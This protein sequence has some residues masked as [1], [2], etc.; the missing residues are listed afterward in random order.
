MGTIEIT[1]NVNDGWVETYATFW[2]S[3]HLGFWGTAFSSSETENPGCLKA[4]YE[5]SLCT[6][7][8]A[9]L[10]F[11][12]TS[13]NLPK[14]AKITGA[15]LKIYGYGYSSAV[16]ISVQEGTQ[17]DTLSLA[18]YSEFT[19]P[20]FGVNVFDFD[21]SG[22]NAIAFNEDGLSYLNQQ[23]GSTAKLCLREYDHDYLDVQPNDI[24]KSGMYFSDVSGSDRK[25]VLE[26]TYVNIESPVTVVGSPS[27]GEVYRV[28]NGT[29][30]ENLDEETG[31]DVTTDEA[32]FSFEDD[33][34]A[35]RR[36]YFYFD[37]SDLPDGIT[38]TGVT[39]KGNGSVSDPGDEGIGASLFKGTQNDTLTVED[40]DAFTGNVL[41]SLDPDDGESGW[42]DFVLN[43]EGVTAVN[44]MLSQTGKL[45]KFCLR[46]TRFDVNRESPLGTPNLLYFAIKSADDPDPELHPR[47]VISFD[48]PADQ[49]NCEASGWYWYDGAC[50]LELPNNQ[51][52]CEENGYYWYGN[53]CHK[54]LPDNESE[55]SGYSYYWYYWECRLSNKLAVI[56]CACIDTLENIWLV[57]GH[58]V[59]E[60]D[61]VFVSLSGSDEP[62][63]RTTGFE[64]Y[65]AYEYAGGLHG[66]IAVIQFTSDPPDP[67]GKVWCNVKGMKNKNGSLIENP[68]EIITHFLTNYLGMTSS[69]YNETGFESAKVQ[70]GSDGHKGAGMIKDHPK[71]IDVIREVAK[72]IGATL[73]FD[74]DG[75]LNIKGLT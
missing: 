66:K 13:L 22:V 68:I 18:D 24:F 60:I 62:R 36:Y 32:F 45:I 39:F 55:C 2:S 33:G 17:S 50:H 35:N 40:Y 30:Q 7:S 65:P 41:S 69:H 11:D 34:N 9:F 54:D 19:G 73:F 63:L 29:W 23:A 44:D 31:E 72:S 21:A 3:C 4:N 6:I 1:G 56:P 74:R 48:L 61:E 64:K 5:D 37:G 28:P 58:E 57:A 43:A 26:L 67:N 53:A 59:L 8:R 42:F 20:L 52:E 10:Y 15:R 16:R 46:S 47:V 51:S 70:A 25:P 71:G 27:D 75:K 49:E 12:L 14:Y 38:V